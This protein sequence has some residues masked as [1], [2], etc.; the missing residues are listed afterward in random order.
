LLT[1]MSVSCISI[2]YLTI[3]TFKPKINT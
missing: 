3:F 2:F 1:V